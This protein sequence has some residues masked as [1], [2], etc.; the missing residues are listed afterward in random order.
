[1]IGTTTAAIGTP[2]PPSSLTCVDGDEGEELG[3][4]DEPVFE[5]SGVPSSMT[6]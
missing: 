2:E 5:G 4:V 1:M 3:V 6:A